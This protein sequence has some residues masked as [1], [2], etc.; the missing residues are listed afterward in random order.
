MSWNFRQ[1]I[2]DVRA[3]W[4]RLGKGHNELEHCDPVEI[5]RMAQEIGLSSRELLD[6]A[7]KSQDSTDLLRRLLVVLQFDPG[8]IDPALMRDLERC[9]AN[10]LNKRQ[11]AH[12][13]DTQI[14]PAAWP[15]YCLN[16]DTLKARMAGKC[17]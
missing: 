13:L 14:K 17:H 5:V 11:C 1:I 15:S 3:E 7:G 6:L 10:C 16:S 2:S 9:C 4:R 12:D 8:K